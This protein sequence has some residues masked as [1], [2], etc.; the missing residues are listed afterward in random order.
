M[1]V[2]SV[3]SN[4]ADGL[5]N[6]GREGST[7]SGHLAE[8]RWAQNRPQI[9]D[10]HYYYSTVYADRY[11]ASESGPRGRSFSRQLTAMLRSCAVH[12]HG[13]H[14]INVYVHIQTCLTDG[15]TTYPGLPR[16]WRRTLD[17]TLTHTPRWAVT[18][19]PWRTVHN[20]PRQ[21]GFSVAAYD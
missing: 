15:L 13:N 20:T 17:H 11:F 6:M 9:Q 16:Q 1:Y 5:L 21:R 19:P 8:K 10:K 12:G 14:Q 7:R 2:Q 3:H 4:Q 18:L